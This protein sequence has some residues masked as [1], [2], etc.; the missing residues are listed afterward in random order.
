MN[1]LESVGLGLALTK[2]QFVAQV[3]RH[4]YACG[5]TTETYIRF[6]RSSTEEQKKVHRGVATVTTTFL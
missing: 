1:H 5:F 6:K 4:P 3:K 2:L